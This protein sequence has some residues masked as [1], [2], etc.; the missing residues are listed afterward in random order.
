VTNP[1]LK[2]IFSDDDCF[3]IIDHNEVIRYDE[4]ETSNN[5]ENDVE[6][7][8]DDDSDEESDNFDENCANASLP[9]PNLDFS[10][11]ISNL[12]KFLLKQHV[13]FIKF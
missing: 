3:D 8:V 6:S 12:F 10:N 4:D 11:L 7:I 2:L 9:E 13:L 5:L 1:H